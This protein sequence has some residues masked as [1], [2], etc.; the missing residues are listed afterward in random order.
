[1]RT[2]GMPNETTAFA[3]SHRQKK[4]WL[5]VLAVLAVLVV[6]ATVAALTMP[7]SA[8][9]APATP[10]T[11]ATGETAAPESSA[12]PQDNAAPS[13]TAQ[14][15]TVTEQAE[16]ETAA[17]PTAAQVPEDYTVQ[18]TVRDEENGFAVTVYAPEGV[19]PEDAV[20]SATLLTE[21]DE[22]YQQAEQALA[23]ETDGSSYG[24]A[25]LDIH[26]EDAEGNEVE[27]Q[28]DVFVSIDAVGLIPEDADPESVTV[29]HHEEQPADADGTAVTVETVADTAPADE[30]VEG[31][32]AATTPDA[33]TETEAEATTVTAPEGK[34]ET[35][36]QAAFPVDGFSTFTITY[37][38]RGEKYTRPVSVL[39]DG[40]ELTEEQLCEF[41]SVE[42]VPQVNLTLDSW[43]S[44]WVRLTSLLQDSG[45]NNT[46]YL[47]GRRYQFDHAAN[48]SGI[49]ITWVRINNNS[50]ASAGSW[51][52]YGRS[53]RLPRNQNDQIITQVDIDQY[54]F[55]YP[56][57]ETLRLYYYS[58]EEPGTI[59]TADTS[60]T[61][62]ISLFDYDGKH[63]NDVLNEGYHEGDKFTFDGTSEG[64]S[65]NGG[66]SYEYPYFSAWTQRDGGVTQGIVK[67]QLEDG[68]PVLKRSDSQSLNVLF[69]PNNSH[70][71]AYTGLNGLFT[72]DEETGY[73]TF[74]SSL[75]FANIDPDK[76]NDQRFTVYNRPNNGTSE[77]SSKTPYFMPF[78]DYG[79]NQ[80]DKDANY[81]FGM[82]IS[83]QFLMPKDGKIN[84]NDKTFSFSGDD[85][86]WVYIDD[87]LILDM[88]G[89]H[90]SNAGYINFGSGQVHIDKKM[91][92]VSQ[93]TETHE[94][95]DKYI[96][97]L[98]YAAKAGDNAWVAANLEQRDEHWYLKDYTQHTLRFFY[99]ERGA[100]D[101]NCKIE[102]NLYTLQSNSLTVGKEIEAG[103]S[104][105]PEIENW[106][107]N[108]EYTFRVL[109][110]NAKPDT[111]E[112]DDLF[113][114]P[115]KMFTIYEGDR[116]TERTGTVGEDGTFTLHAG[117]RAFFA[118][119]AENSGGYYVQELVE[120]EYSAQFGT[121][122]VNVNPG[123][124]ETFAEDE[125]PAG[126]DGVSSNKLDAS[127]AGYVLFTNTVETENLSLLTITKA[128]AEGSVFPA[129]ETF[130]VYA[131][132]DGEPVDGTFGT[133]NTPV[134][135]ADGFADFQV[136][137]T[138][139]IP[140]LT[141]ANFTIYEVGGEGYEVTYTAAQTFPE[142]KGGAY[143]LTEVK[144]EDGVETVQGEVGDLEHTTN[145]EGVTDATGATMAVTLTNKKTS[146]DLTIVKNIY[147]L[148][149]EQVV[150][151]VNGDYSKE[152]CDNNDGHIG[153]HKHGLRFDVDYFNA[154]ES[155]IE[156]NYKDKDSFIDDWTFD[157]QQTLT[158]KNAESED[159]SFISDNAAWSGDINEE[160]VDMD[161]QGQEDD[162][163]E[164]KHYQNSSLTYV[165]PAEGEP[166]YQ[167]TITIQ[168]VELTDWYHVMETRTT[169]DGYDLAASVAT[170]VTGTGTEISNLIEGNN[171]TK[172][173]FQLTG[174]TTVI[175]TNRY[176]HNTVTVNMKKVES[177]SSNGLAGAKFY[178]YYTETQGDTSTR[179]YYQ[180]PAAGEEEAKWLEQTNDDE[181]PAGATQI[182]SGPDGALQVPGLAVDREYT[183]Q[184]VEAPA[185]YQ[186][187]TNTILIRVGADG[188]VTVKYDNGEGVAFTVAERADKP[189]SSTKP[190]DPADIT[191]LI[192]NTTGAE[193]PATGGAG[194]TFLTCSGLLMMAAAVGGYAL[195]RRR[196]KGAR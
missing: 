65:V 98:L 137:T 34:P 175:F 106:L 25:A 80:T 144:T 92:S 187:P 82:T 15:D 19:I 165:V 117:E 169:V 103:S 161:T 183:L 119:I 87:V 63:V 132:I 75:N 167:Y 71:K 79:V 146:A 69:D 83:T 49:A 112:S 2:N 151:L 44:G 52:R 157:V 120:S 107:G 48:E 181:V 170:T 179:Y 31:T 94:P 38:I 156:D 121:V 58:A 149:A 61:V 4:T 86:V 136:G 89:I 84:D 143:T 129:G 13:D 148:N 21:G 110:Q 104:T 64:S 27:P 36:V 142:D 93:S 182:V 123:G 191:Y 76:E 77:G 73:Y 55:E 133:G 97:D 16:A 57:G 102:F 40:V 26:L 194:T 23:E 154:K 128:A 166:Y 88:G 173:A 180:A 140:V 184:E 124:G 101:S 66:Q 95:Y 108:L 150:H 158:K 74:D 20:L 135:F 139:S 50:D 189:D 91:I 30:G 8:M 5:T 47:N 62:Q 42:E 35:E 22:A 6:F 18:R 10:E 28:G 111:T 53:D 100:V 43:N 12:L 115:S 70:N 127:A 51:L 155:A 162:Q 32:V 193:L 159:D 130:R 11:A 33:T 195:R 186:L 99:L 3:S 67:N 54:I 39:L 192:P 134:T 41:L 126:F 59:D 145:V 72:Y 46:G 188:L 163:A 68:Y 190:W 160:G 147:G 131:E 177:G 24:F 17:L 178:L 176:T 152:T 29:Q 141:G 113:I 1:M 171:G 81:H 37:T 174:D 96:G 9:T 90:D 138:V 60:K 185:G 164:V 85:D 78:N 168:D 125:A 172:T 122:Q 109:N 153:N 7:A 105:T 196:G 118:D 56:A 114:K 116:P 14:S 45:I